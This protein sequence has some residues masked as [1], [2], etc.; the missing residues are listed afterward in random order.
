M[1]VA[2]VGEQERE[3]WGD[4]QLNCILE[5]TMSSMR[6]MW[7]DTAWSVDKHRAS[8][9]SGY[10]LSLEKRSRQGD[11]VTG[12][13]AIATLAE[14]SRCSFLIPPRTPAGMP[15]IW[16]E[17]LALNAQLEV[18]SYGEKPLV[19]GIVVAASTHPWL[20]WH[21]T[22]V[23]VSIFSWGRTPLEISRQPY[24]SL[25]SK[26]FFLCFCQAYCGWDRVTLWNNGRVGEHCPFRRMKQPDTQAESVLGRPV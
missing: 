2:G 18:N 25:S 1:K 21:L 8:L 15:I 20:L 19:T 5:F 12:P 17:C 9:Q 6:C 4:L 3:L 24:A 7:N 13:L 11:T 10:H 22:H 23:S 16:R 14:F 26:I